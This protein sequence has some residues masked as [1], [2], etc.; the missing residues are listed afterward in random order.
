MLLQPL[1]DAPALGLK[2]E[3]FTFGRSNLGDYKGV[4]AIHCT[5]RPIASGA[6]YEVVDHN[7][8]NGTFLN[9]ER[10]PKSRAVLLKV[11]DRITLGRRNG[12]IG[13]VVEANDFNA[14]LTRGTK[15][16]LIDGPGKV[17][18]N[19]GGALGNIPV[20]GT[21]TK[22]VIDLSGKA[23]ADAPKNIYDAPK[24]LINAPGALVDGAGQTFNNA[25]K[26][27]ND[28]VGNVSAGLGLKAK[29][30]NPWWDEA[31]E[32]QQQPGGLWGFVG[33]T[34]K[35]VQDAGKSVFVDAPGKAVGSV[36]S[37]L[38]MQKKEVDETMA[39]MTEGP[40]SPGRVGAVMEEPVNVA[41]NVAD[42]VLK[43]AAPSPGPA[44]GP[45]RTQ[46]ATNAVADQTGAAIETTAETVNKIP[47]VGDAGAAVSKIPLVSGAA[48]SV[49][50]V[51]DTTTAVGGDMKTLFLDAPGK[52]LSSY[53]E[54]ANSIPLVKQSSQ[55]VGSGVE[56]IG[57]VP[58]VRGVGK[59]V[60]DGA[61]AVVGGAGAVI[62][63]TGAA[64]GTSV[65]AVGNIPVVGSASK[66]IYDSGAK[67]TGG[68][69]DAGT[70]AFKTKFVDMPAQLFKST[71]EA[72]VSAGDFTVKA[73]GAVVAG[74]SSA[75]DDVRKSVESA[76]KAL[77]TPFASGVQTTADVASGATA[78]TATMASVPEDV[79]A[80]DQAG[81]S[82][83]P[84]RP[85]AD[86]AKYHAPAN[87]TS[88]S[89]TDAIGGAGSAVGG[90]GSAF[91]LGA[92]P[93]VA[94]AGSTAAA[95]TAVPTNAATNAATNAVDTV[96]ARDEYE[97]D[98]DYESY[99]APY[100]DERR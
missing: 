78:A 94:E 21:G 72:V 70:Q 24:N 20:V 18:G 3:P 30:E 17:L 5:V 43:P 73:P 60:T 79:V 13:F 15:A 23:I 84:T 74:A 85:E 7:S 83:P 63:G 56:Q 80:P 86:G 82:V 35:S 77:S 10:V 68:I 22:S 38:G 40:P 31:G 51:G 49:V 8:T 64:L 12:K 99:D 34:G 88:F 66:G 37:V 2:Q 92:V 36:G 25:G 16:S 14:Q 55:M 87:S 50:N 98:Y 59:N 75:V 27:L 32:K 67:V 96:A 45:V 42:E 44:P 81:A 4:S 76:P 53:G 100:E 47:L 93:V 11:G 90:L 39:S 61:G 54:A 41:A 48:K 6:G 52:A 19:A 46:T 65:D 57:N 9:A 58:L 29:E 1:H 95:V 28:G 97:Y 62:G 26:T 71:S 89:L 69:G 91:G 33:A